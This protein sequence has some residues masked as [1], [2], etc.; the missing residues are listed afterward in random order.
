MAARER[1]WAS[2]IPRR[3]HLRCFHFGHIKRQ[4]TPSFEFMDFDYCPL[5]DSRES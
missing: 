5:W 4:M 3:A 2:Y 1:A